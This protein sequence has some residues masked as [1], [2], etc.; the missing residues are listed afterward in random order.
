M[1]GSVKEEVFFYRTVI[2]STSCSV[3]FYSGPRI[4]IFVY[5]GDAGQTFFLSEGLVRD[6]IAR[7]VDVFYVDGRALPVDAGPSCVL[8]FIFPRQGGTAVCVGLFASVAFLYGGPR[9]AINL[10]AGRGV[11]VVGGSNESCTILISGFESVHSVLHL[12]PVR[13]VWV[14]LRVGGDRAPPVVA[15]I[16]CL[17]QVD[18]AKVSRGPQHLFV[19]R[20]SDGLP[21]FTL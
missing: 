20:I 17:Y 6:C 4:F 11:V 8:W 3:V 9:R 13:Y 2:L 14:A 5:L 7:D 10:G 21:S 19:F 15:R 16:C 12:P 18:R 1:L